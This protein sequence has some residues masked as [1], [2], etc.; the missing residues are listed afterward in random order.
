VRSARTGLAAALTA[1]ALATVAGPAALGASRTVTVEGWHPRVL[2]FSGGSLLW[3]EAATVRVNPARIAGSPA[4]GQRFDYYRAEV[5]RTGLDRAARRFTG[6]PETAAAIR[7][8]IA[9]M[10]P[11][12]L[13]PTGDGGF[14]VA[15]ESRRFA[16]PV[17]WCCD[18]DGVE[19]VIESDGRADAPVTVS[20]AWTGAA[21][22]FAQLTGGLQTLR[23]ADPA[24]VA[25]PATAPTG[26]AASPGLIALSRDGVAWVDPGD[27][28]TLRLRGAGGDPAAAVVTSVPLPGPALRVWGSPGLFAV[29]ARVGGR[30]ALLRVDE[31]AAA[32]AVRVWT[33]ARVPRVALG[34]GAIA[35]ADGRRV[36]ASR[37]GALRIVVT[38][39]RIVDAVGVDGRRLA[40]IER[41]TRRGT[42]VGVV[43]LGR[44]R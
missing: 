9:S 7:T 18:A 36:R 22:R 1:V 23:T 17:V 30:V 27:A 21:V 34:G 38:G 39:R 25:P 10:A 4:G 43:R 6:D 13:S 3:T 32:R 41:G 19:A 42:R 24:G 16:P 20:A 11:G 26:L 8:S 5:F 14:V 40:W 29:A 35:V 44:V 31:G 33:G 15:P 12:T 37:S 28:A 2:A